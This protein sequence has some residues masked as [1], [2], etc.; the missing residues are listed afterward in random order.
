M[1]AALAQ[2]AA[3]EKKNKKN[4]KSAA[5]SG[6]AAA[7]AAAAVQEE[8]TRARIRRDVLAHVWGEFR[9]R[10]FKFK[11]AHIRGSWEMSRSFPDLTVAEAYRRP[12][13]DRSEETF[14]WGEVW[15]DA[16]MHGCVHVHAVM[17]AMCMRMHAC[18]Y[19]HISNFLGWCCVR[20]KPLRRERYDIRTKRTDRLNVRTQ[21]NANKKVKGK[22]LLFFF[23]FLTHVSFSLL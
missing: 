4:N 6:T 2:H 1:S 17:W 11:H 16:C 15:R 18:V 23:H 13:A 5:V 8:A 19:A 9:K 3:E 22:Y 7:A 14:A 20:G 21:R 12:T 10:L